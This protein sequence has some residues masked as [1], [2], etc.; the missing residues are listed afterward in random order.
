LIN[1]NAI[2][3]GESPYGNYIVDPV[4]LHPF[5]PSYDVSQ[6]NMAVLRGRA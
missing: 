3:V 6:M 2:F 5:D 1:A 4:N